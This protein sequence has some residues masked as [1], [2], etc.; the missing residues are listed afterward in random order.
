MPTGPKGAHNGPNRAHTGR[1]G[2]GRPP[3][4]G[5]GIGS[6]LLQLADIGPTERGR[7]LEAAE[8]AAATHD[9]VTIWDV[10]IDHVYASD[11][12]VSLTAIR[13]Y[14]DALAVPK[15]AD[16]GKPVYPSVRDIADLP[17]RKPDPAKVRAIER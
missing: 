7:L 14:S 4:S 1:R 11:R 16:P 6:R 12:K 9:G 10:L 15:A 3:G 5:T 13:L 8:R 17:E 2:P